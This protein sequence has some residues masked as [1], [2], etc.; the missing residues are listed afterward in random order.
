MGV[1][2]FW[3]HELVSEEIARKVLRGLKFD[4]ETVSYTHLDVYKRQAP[5]RGQHSDRSICPEV[6]IPGPASDLAFDG[7]GRIGRSDFL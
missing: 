4:N 7:H 3:D 2:H 5:H 1:D 6:W